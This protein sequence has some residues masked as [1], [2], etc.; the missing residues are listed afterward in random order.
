MHKSWHRL[1]WIF[2]WVGDKKKKKWWLK[3]RCPLLPCVHLAQGCGQL[4]T[5]YFQTLILKKLPHRR[6]KLVHKPVTFAHARNIQDTCTYMYDRPVLRQNGCVFTHD[7]PNH[8][9][10]K[11]TLKKKKKDRKK[12]RQRCRILLLSYTSHFTHTEIKT[13]HLLFSVV[14]T[15][16]S[17]FQIHSLRIFIS[18]TLSSRM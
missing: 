8:S 14:E 16:D 7:E 2:L 9:P 4:L 6:F 12:K 17:H 10:F 18:N 5:D 1:P 11:I 15:S 3:T 13:Q